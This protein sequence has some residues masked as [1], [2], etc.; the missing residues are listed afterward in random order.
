M[1]NLIPLTSLCGTI[2]Y[3]SVCPKLPNS[4]DILLQKMKFIPNFA[5]DFQKINSVEPFYNIH[6][7]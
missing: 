6:V 3:L 7:L 5:R 4:L 1:H 2:P